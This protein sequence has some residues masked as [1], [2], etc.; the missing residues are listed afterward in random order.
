MIH[1]LP[2]S[3]WDL[4]LYVVLS[5]KLHYKIKSQ[6]LLVTIFSC[7]FPLSEIIKKETC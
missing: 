2:L 4:S 6:E 1:S 7:P 3:A 5:N